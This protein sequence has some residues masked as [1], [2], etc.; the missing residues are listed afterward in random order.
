MRGD[1]EWT[2]LPGLVEAAADRF[3]DREA[4]VDGPVRLTF[5]GLAARVREAAAA[6]MAQGV[7][8]GDRVAIW[9]PNSP[10]WVVAA[11]GAVS[12]GGVLVPINTRFKGAE[13]AYVL[14]ASGTGL[15]FVAGEFLGN[16]YVGMLEQ[17]AGA[18][19]AARPLRGLPDLRR[20]VVLDGPAASPYL[21]WAEF[22]VAGGMISAAR[23][24]G[25]AAGVRTGDLSDVTF[26][27]GT[28]GRPKGV[29]ITHG[30]TLRTFATWSDVVGLDTGDRYL[31]VNPFF[32]TFGYK[33]GILACLM[34]GATIVPHPVFDPAAV[35]ARVGA[36]RIS[37][38]PGPPALYSAILDHP[39][40]A[41]HDLASLRLAVT[42]AAV[43][44]LDLVRRIRDDL[45][46]GTVLTAY[47]LTESTGTA[48]MCRRDD[49]LETIARTS[50]R[51][52]PGTEVRVV[53]AAG[54]PVPPGRPGEVVIRG[55]NVM[56]GYLDDPEAT[57]AAIDP[58]G[59]LHTGDVGE[60]D[61]RGYLRITDR[62]KD[63][64]VVGGF[65]AYPAEIE[66]QIARH[67]GVADVAVVGVPDG[68]L[69]EVGKA[70]VVPRPGAEIDPAELIGWSRERMANYK[71]PR[72][73]ELVDELPRNASGKV[74][75]Y[76]LRSPAEA[77][78]REEVT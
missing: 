72:Y 36:E 66:Q 61:G 13:A 27:S 23:V 52:I 6:A 9:A 41:A 39:D 42:G 44:P 67:H 51:A 56:R 71:V 24:S 77:R 2:S 10:A 46:F 4:L 76:A 21:S 57:A 64:Y 33:A 49:D 22:I 18:G 7:G 70:F 53:D 8:P 19:D 65:N 11:L 30:Q 3:G 50:G 17:A 5:R 47:G 26:T 48:T 12:A 78:A 31:V 73:V 14:R 25:R 37:V 63:M 29:V 75:K 68:R 32:H 58:D 1:E 74:L 35:L 28:T 38:L 54:Q 16:D 59:W 20:V 43:I 62:I 55:Y 45:G 40:R 34:R 60:M 69:G 15:L